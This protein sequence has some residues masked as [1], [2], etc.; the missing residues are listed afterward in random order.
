MTFSPDQLRLINLVI[1]R[2]EQACRY[3]LKHQ[4]FDSDTDPEFRSGWEVAAS[5]CE[6]A[7]R[8]SVMRHV[9]DDFTRVP[10]DPPSDPHPDVIGIRK[11][12]R[13]RS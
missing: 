7:I 11:D 2:A 6:G 9:E 13:K 1:E 4:N 12:G 8:D 10:F 5:V 3:A